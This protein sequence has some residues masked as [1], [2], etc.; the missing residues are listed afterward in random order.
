[1]ARKDW[2]YPNI[3]KEMA[4]RLDE[5]LFVN[6]KLTSRAKRLGV[7]NKQELLCIIIDRFLMEHGIKD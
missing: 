3:P 1:M 4:D 7:K 6:G 2:Y 5:F